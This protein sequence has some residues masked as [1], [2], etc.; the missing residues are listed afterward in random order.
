MSQLITAL[1]FTNGGDRILAA[2]NSNHIATGSVSAI[3]DG[4][5]KADN[6]SDD[7]KK[8]TLT[9]HECAAGYGRVFAIDAMPG[10]DDKALLCH[11]RKLA[12]V[13][14]GD[15]TCDTYK[16]RHS[17]VIHGIPTLRLGRD[18]ARVKMTTL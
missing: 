16:V 2:T 17:S 5:D 4:L 9:M 13:Q 12:V 11:R 6:T 7:D 3:L 1:G 8:A 14:F 15:S 10:N 18:M